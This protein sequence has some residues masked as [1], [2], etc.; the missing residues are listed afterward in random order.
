MSEEGVRVLP[1]GIESGRAP[2]PFFT[3][4]VHFAESLLCVVPVFDRKQVPLG[5]EQPERVSDV[6]YGE[7]ASARKP[8]VSYEPPP[9]SPYRSSGRRLRRQRLDLLV[10]KEVEEAGPVVWRSVGSHFEV[11][12]LCRQWYAHF[13]DSG[14]FPVPGNPVRKRIR[15]GFYISGLGRFWT[16]P[17]LRPIGLA[18]PWEMYC[19][20]FYLIRNNGY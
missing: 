15:D 12:I 10:R 16:C 18:F 11:R 7:F 1:V 2:V 6:P 14:N 5:R 4:P 3:H 17:T 8:P 13:P 9:I 20:T 19:Q